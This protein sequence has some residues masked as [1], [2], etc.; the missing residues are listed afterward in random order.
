MGSIT[1]EI[2]KDNRKVYRA[3]V[4]R[5]GQRVTKRFSR[6][7]DAKNWISRTESEIIEGKKLPKLKRHTL[8]D[9]IERYLLEVNS[10]KKPDTQKLHSAQLEWFKKAIGTIQLRDLSNDDLA[11]AREK[12]GKE[13]SFKP[14]GT[15]PITRSASTLNRYFQVL[16]HCLNT[17]KLDW[18]WIQDVPRICKLREP[19]GRTRYLTPDEAKS[20]FTELNR[21]NRYD[22][23]LICLICLTVGSRLRETC[24]LKW[25]EVDFET[26]V[27]RFTLTKT[28]EVRDIPIPPRLTQ[29][30]LE[31]RS[32]RGNHEYLFP[33]ERPSKRPFIYDL[34]KKRFTRTCKTLGLTDVV[35]HSLRHTAASWA[36]QN[37]T[38][39]K[40][41][42]ELLGHRN[43][44][45]TDRYSH[46]NVEHLRPVVIAV[47]KTISNQSILSLEEKNYETS[48]KE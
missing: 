14:N 10:R 25:S 32:I 28:D 1:V 40:V 18:G 6:I 26:E 41:I 3:N 8:K 23:Y 33:V 36:T 16:N 19:K 43:V 37:N 27:L 20:L 29:A 24:A 45:T 42:A 11:K 38:N 4:R 21:S 17:A 5:Q 44:S 46:L 47:E 15:K 48:N 31:W 30:L 35:I 9:A 12:L 34:V 2:K 39:R 13:V 22:V 7:T